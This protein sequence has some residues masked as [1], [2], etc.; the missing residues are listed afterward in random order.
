[1]SFPLLLVNARSCLLFAPLAPIPSRL[2]RRRCEHDFP[3]VFTLAAVGSVISYIYSAPPLKL[4]QNGWIGNY[5]LVR[6]R[7]ALA[8]TQRC[9]ALVGAPPAWPRPTEDGLHERP[10]FHEKDTGRLKY[11]RD[12]FRCPHPPLRPRL[13]P[14]PLPQGSSYISLP[15]WAGQAV[16]GTCDP[17]LACLTTPPAEEP[18]L[19]R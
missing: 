3:I 5:A 11:E 1:M 6:P 13:Y 9:L 7:H 12:A 4:K 16:F 19:R 10:T 18:V 14:Y 2:L 15:W 8:N 17:P